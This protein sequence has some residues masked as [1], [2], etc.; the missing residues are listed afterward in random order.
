MQ[1]CDF[2]ADVLAA[3]LLSGW[4]ETADACVREHIALCDNCREVAVAASAVDEL[5]A[6]TVSVELP[7]AGRVWWLAQ[8]RARREAAASARRPI[9]AVQ[10]IAFVA[11]VCVIGTVLISADVETLIATH[12]L[13]VAGMAAMLLLVPAAVLLAVRRE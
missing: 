6:A 11:A 4:P 1:E 2:E 12:A 10:S 9:A 13:M 7:D 8:L 3:S 5:R